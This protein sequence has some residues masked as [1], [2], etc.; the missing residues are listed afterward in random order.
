MSDYKEQ[1]HL[2]GLI[3][4]SLKI[5]QDKEI[6]DYYK[7]NERDA[8]KLVSDLS[9]SIDD[10]SVIAGMLMYAASL[11]EKENTLYDKALKIVEQYVK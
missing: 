10:P 7:N 11:M 3:R 1:N 2:S 9:K 4:I 5:P 6:E 8:E